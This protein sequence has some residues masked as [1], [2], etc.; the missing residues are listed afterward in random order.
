MKRHKDVTGNI[1]AD[2]KAIE[3][4]GAFTGGSTVKL[5]TMDKLKNLTS[6]FSENFKKCTKFFFHLI[7]ILMFND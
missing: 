3:I 7:I 5:K 1:A 6:I 4:S 2:L